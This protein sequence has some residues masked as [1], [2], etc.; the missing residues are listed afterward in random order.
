M[1]ASAGFELQRVIFPP[2]GE[3]DAVELYV[4]AGSALGLHLVEDDR[5]YRNPKLPEDKLHVVGSSTVEAHHE[6]FLSRTSMTV[7]PGQHISFGTY[8]NAFPASYWRRWTNVTD[9]KLKIQLEGTG[10]VIVF[11]SNARG[12]PQ[13]LESIRVDGVENI[14]LDLSLEMFGDGGWYW[15]E[16]VAGQSELNLLGASWSTDTKPTVS[17]EKAATVQITT[18]N[19]PAFCID[20]ARVLAANPYALKSVGEILIVDQGTRK[21]VDEPGF[22]EVR[23]LLGDK[24]RIIEQ[25]NLGGSGGFSRGMAEAVDNGSDF[26][27][28][29]DDDVAVEP[30]S[31]ERIITF[32]RY[33]RR[34]TIVGG[35]M[36]DLYSR[37]TLHTFGEVVDPYRLSWVT[38]DTEIEYRHDF[39]QRNLRQTPWMHRRVDVDFNG[40]WMCLIPTAVIR[41]IGLSLPLFIKWDDAEY[42]LRAKEAG[43]PT[44]S[45]PGAALW[46]VSWIDKDDSLGWQAYFHERNRLISALIHSPFPRG[47]RL[48]RESFQNNVKHLISMQYFVQE[49][50]ILALRDVLRGPQHLH[51]ELRSKLAEVNRLRS[52]HPEARICSDVDDFPAVGLTRGGRGGGT[53]AMPSK[54]DLPSWAAKTV[55]RQVFRKPDLQ[56][57]ERP[58]AHLA[59][60][61]NKWWTLSRYDSVLVSN[62]EGTGVSWLRR[63]PDLLKSKIVEASRLQAQLFR[64]WSTLSAEYRA[65]LP[66]IT[67]MESWRSTFESVADTSVKERH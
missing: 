28:L 20:N 6:D 45:L 58:Q 27:L 56:S 59:H 47:G 29:L 67:S 31:I 50:R 33:S 44:V 37:T 12:V 26:V 11:R 21:V 3:F 4:D 54:K 55:L 19:K 52:Q 53:T 64:Q 36:F 22:D 1:S 25:D 17:T 48:L 23:H 7:R 42:S 10:S 30:D 63:N 61:E 65:A 38:P 8:F 2:P 9:V 15:F 16:M 49:A 32:A 46:H 41:E 51:A 35:H 34:P 62:A 5:L 40:W 57:L 60:R 24:L 18:M 14:Q 43:F 13:R 39:R 66:R